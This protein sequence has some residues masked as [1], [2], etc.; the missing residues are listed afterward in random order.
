MYTSK[1]IHNIFLIICGIL[2]F[3]LLWHNISGIIHN[4]FHA[5]DFGIYQQAIYEIADF[6]S[7][8]PFLTIRNVHIFNDHFDP[9]IY[10]AIPFTWISNFHPV[11]LILFELLIF[12]FFIFLIYRLTPYKKY[13]PVLFLLLLTTKAYLSGILY[14]IHPSAW[15]VIPIFLMA[16]YHHKGNNRGFILSVLALCFFREVFPLAIIFMSLSFYRQKNYRLFLGSLILGLFFSYFIYF[17]RPI[18]FGPTVDYGGMVLKEMI[19]DPLKILGQINLLPPLKILYPFFI[20]MYFVI[21]DE[22]KRFF[23]KPLFLFWLPLFALHFLTNKVH[24]QYGPFLIAPLWGLMLFSSGFESFLNNKK[25]MTVTILLFLASSMGTYTKTFK[26][27]FLAKSKKCIISKEKRQA[28][29]TLKKFIHDIPP[30]KTI[31]ATGGVIP[32]ILKPGM[33]IYQAGLFSKR[34]SSYDY[35]LLEKNGSG[36]I[37]PYNKSDIEKTINHCPYMEII[38]N[39]FYFLAKGPI[40]YPCL[41]PLW[42]A[43]P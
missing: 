27:V 41:Q 11:G 31:L 38:H 3:S 20:P 18:L 29:A 10:L 25:A 33:K 28:T 13:F 6:K 1:K 23:F 2:T 37:F 24:T 14:P 34:L 4:C 39:K 35:L 17:I 21:R 19:N 32:T 36:D 12:A 9:V 26:M 43:W 30:E 40:P 22:G 42:D 15:S 7:F 8:N 16:Y 5:T